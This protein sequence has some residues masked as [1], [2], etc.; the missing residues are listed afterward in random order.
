MPHPPPQIAAGLIGPSPRRTALP[1]PG[2]FDPGEH[3]IARL[4]RGADEP[5][6]SGRPIAE[7]VDQFDNENLVQTGGEVH[8][9]GRAEPGFDAAGRP[10]FGHQP[11]VPIA[12]LGGTS[13]SGI[14]HVQSR[15]VVGAFIG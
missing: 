11:Q 4:P 7:P 9:D 3:R 6:V 8:P 12:K 15:G 1:R 14:V 13:G 2:E 10:K 5:A